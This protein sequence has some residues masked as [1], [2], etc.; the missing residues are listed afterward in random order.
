MVKKYQISNTNEIKRD[1]LVVSNTRKI[2]K[3]IPKAGQIIQKF[4][5]TIEG[6]LYTDESVVPRGIMLY[7]YHSGVIK[8]EDS[9][10][11]IRNKK[12]RKEEFITNHTKRDNSA[13]LPIAG[14]T[15]DDYGHTHRFII[16]KDRTV[17]IYEAVHPDEKEIK[18]THRYTGLW[19]NGNITDNKSSCFPNCERIY[20]IKGIGNHS[21]K[22]SLTK[23]MNNIGGKY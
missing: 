8:T 22:L 4:R 11:V 5:S 13:R 14:K 2:N 18:H 15:T 23:I 17:D 6:Y 1:R 3:K 12:R 9:K 21:H 10:I 16:N 20:G 7:K 19:P